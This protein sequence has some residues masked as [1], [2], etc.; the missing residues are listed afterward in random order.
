MDSYT[1]KDSEFLGY[2][3]GYSQPNTVEPLPRGWRA[4][5]SPSLASCSSRSTWLIVRSHIGGLCFG[6][7][8]A[9][10]DT[11]F[12]APS[13]EPR[14]LVV[15]ALL[16]LPSQ[17]LLAVRACHAA[18]M[19]LDNDLVIILYAYAC[20][21]NTHAHAV[22]YTVVLLVHTS[23]YDFNLTSIPGSIFTLGTPVWPWPVIQELPNV[24]YASMSTSSPGQERLFFGQHLSRDY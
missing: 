18:T 5:A 2:P 11:T 7:I 21:L 8:G 16:M 15:E 13:A 3:S 12:H 17:A 22:L 14:L 23:V 4:V 1:P 24:Q 9:Y 10:S 19:D 20:I 6:F